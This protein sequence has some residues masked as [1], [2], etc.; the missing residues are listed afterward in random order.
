VIELGLTPAQKLDMVD[1]LTHSHRVNNRVY[2]L[3]MNMQVKSEIT[4]FLLDGH[5]DID[6]E[7][8]ITRSAEVKL[9]DMDAGLDHDFDSPAEGGVLPT[10]MIRIVHEIAR[11]GGPWAYA[12]PLFT[13]PVWK[14]DR[15]GG[16]LTIVGQGKESLSGKGIFYPWSASAGWKRTDLIRYALQRFTGEVNFKF[17][18]TSPTMGAAWAIA[19]GDP[20]MPALR[21]VARNGGYNLFYDGMGYAV[22]RP[23]NGPVVF[24]F[25]GTVATD[26]PNPS[27]SLEDLT[28][29]VRVIGGAPKGYAGK[30]TY[31]A[32]PDPA[33]PLHPANLAINGAP[34]YFPEIIEDDALNTVA[35]VQGT[36][37]TVLNEGLTYS[38]D[39][40]FSAKIIPFLE[41]MD[42]YRIS[43]ESMFGDRILK[44][45]T[46]P[47]V[48]DG[49]MSVGYLSTSSRGPAGIKGTILSRPT[50]KPVKPKKKAKK[51]KNKRKNKKRHHKRR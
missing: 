2:V 17:P 28:N 49:E 48:G 39:A 41:E 4:R 37:I 25:D 40:E 8:D 6:A 5:V 47:L 14:T 16:I 18:A 29:V 36:A 22:M 46:I 11:F 21:T 19:A 45:M 27:F 24:T 20:L 51:K 15:E 43:T 23:M 30:Y 35:L 3:D 38:Y 7:A 1:I 42:R 13:G 12:I 44:K 33:H 9:L 50:L 34:R 31:E 26:M 10:R 32:F